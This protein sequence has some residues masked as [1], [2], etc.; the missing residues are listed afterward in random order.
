MDL[1]DIYVTF[2]SKSKEYTF[3]S[4]PRGT[5][6]KIDHIISHK[7]ASTDTRRLNNPVPPI[8]SPWNKAGLY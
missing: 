5:F 8:R 7:Q 6:S 1:A 3:F 2:H 4:A